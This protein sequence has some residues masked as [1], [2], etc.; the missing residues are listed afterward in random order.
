MWRITKGCQLLWRRWDE[1]Y[2]VYNSGSGHTHLLD[3][4][5]AGLLRCLEEHPSN[6]QQLATEMGEELEPDKTPAVTNIIEALLTRFQDLGL[7]E[8][9]QR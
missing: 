2:I 6:S 4:F 1:E 5:G 7:V 9:I 3:G 8:F